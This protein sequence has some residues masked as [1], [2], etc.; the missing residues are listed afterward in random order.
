[1]A[2]ICAGG[3][4]ACAFPKD[5]YNEVLCL[6]KK[7]EPKFLF[8]HQRNLHWAEQLQT[9]MGYKVV[10]IVI[11]DSLDEIHIKS[12]SKTDDIY[13]FD[14]LFNY[15]HK[16]SKSL[17]YLPVACADPTTDVAFIT[18]SSGTTGPPKAVPVSHRGC[19]RDLTFFGRGPAKRGVKFACSS[20]LDYVSGRI[21]L[22]G[23][24]QSGYTAVII[25]CFEP[26]SYL[27]AVEKY[28][29]N[30]IYLGAA[31]FYSLITY[32][33]IENY[34]LSSVK[35]IFPMGAKIVYLDEMRDFIARCPQLTMIRQGYGAT[36]IS[37]CAMNAM[38]PE[39][40][41]KDCNNCGNLIPGM[42]A[43]IID[44]KSGALL[45]CNEEGLLRIRCNTPF[46]GYYD[47]QRFKEPLKQLDTNSNVGN[48]GDSIK[49]FVQDSN[50]MDEDGF[51]ITGD[52][53]YFND[54]EQL[55]IVGREKE[56]MSCRG[57]KKV[58]PQE[59]EDVIS[60]HPLVSKVCVL[61]VPNKIQLTIHCPRAFIV[62]IKSAYD[63]NVPL[64]LTKRLKQDKHSP[65]EEELNFKNEGENKLCQL[66]Q[67]RRKALA[68][69]LMDFV[70]E[71]VGW[72]KQLTG[73][74]MIL[75]SLPILRSAGKINKTYLKSLIDV[76]I[77][78]DRSC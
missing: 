44:R 16:Q 5:P 67:S 29:I 25:D 69:D 59:L 9:D 65:D 62:P 19:L 70:N 63:E 28:K 32:K 51:Y 61:G 6:A 58:R 11:G 76:E 1:M 26:K 52:I 27:E 47:A 38:S 60:E 54:K 53:A 20:S 15:D 18:M 75:D 68:R 77:Y 49:P 7:V 40:Y 36:E 10:G 23:A 72:E 35:V 13:L 39:E 34:D 57:A 21:T 24:V 4:V 30:V 48:T 42:Q 50:T 56:L 17:D 8:C 37:G 31:S 43:K 78:G 3:S 64:E 22:L 66:S 73:G 41:M 55:F 2:I 74:I 33:H 14:S 12:L 45:G 46:L 71:R